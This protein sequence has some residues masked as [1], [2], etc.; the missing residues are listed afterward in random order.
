VML[1]HFEA[2]GAVRKAIS[3]LKKR[4]GT[5]EDTIRELRFDG[6]RIGVG[7][8]LSEF[9]GVLTG[10]PVYTGTEASLNTKGDSR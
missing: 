10:V 7:K 3:V 4:T 8:V 9:R 6:G 5:H 2:F 1:R